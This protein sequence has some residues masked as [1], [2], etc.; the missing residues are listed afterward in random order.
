MSNGPNQ[1]DPNQLIGLLSKQRDL[2]Q[3]LQTL[4]EKQ[5]SMISGDRPERLLG[6]LRERQE[7]VTSLARLNEEM[8]PYRRNW[9]AAYAAL[10][11]ASR[12]RASALLH[13]INGLLRVILQTDRE[14]TALLSARKQSVANSISELSGG[15]AAN[16]AYA[17]QGSR[18]NQAKAADMTG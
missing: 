6:I 14:D 13:E 3:T 7:L 8:G 5:R 16:A 12:E 9:D 17:R 18:G 11:P 10:P 4:S 1:P 2:Y 15:Q